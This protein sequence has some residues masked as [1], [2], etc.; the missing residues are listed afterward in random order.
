MGVVVDAREGNWR[1]QSTDVNRVI[2]PALPIVDE[3]LLGELVEA[4]AA[5]EFSSRY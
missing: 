1:G 5:K 4:R 2:E 3:Q